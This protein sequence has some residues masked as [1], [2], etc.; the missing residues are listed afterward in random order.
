MMQYKY[1]KQQIIEAIKHWQNVLAKIDESRSLLLDAFAN[2][3]GSNVIYSKKPF[4][5]NN[6]QA[7]EIFSIVNKFLFDSRL[8]S[9]PDIRILTYG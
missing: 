4:M 5:L 9:F 7:L 6:A 3:F 8:V 1:T 2:K